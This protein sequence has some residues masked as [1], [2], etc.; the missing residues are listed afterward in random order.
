MGIEELKKS[1]S[2][3]LDIEFK[4]KNE[5]Y[6]ILTWN[7]YGII[8]GNQIRNTYS[9]YKTVN[10]LIDNYKIDGESITKVIKDI[11]ITIE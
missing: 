10:E 11:D 9:I 2:F 7:E 3:G 8:I 1:I 5:I 6:T 4:Y